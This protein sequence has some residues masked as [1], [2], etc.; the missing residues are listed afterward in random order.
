MT[1]C[2]ELSDSMSIRYNIVLNN[3]SASLIAELPDLVVEMFLFDARISRSFHPFNAFIEFFLRILP[4]W[5]I[6]VSF[7]YL[8]FLSDSFPFLIQSLF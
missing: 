4:L 3:L 1:F 8:C 6:I 2:R 5:N 7:L